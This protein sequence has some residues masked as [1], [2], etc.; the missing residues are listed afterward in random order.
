MQLALHINKGIHL[1]GE[2]FWSQNPFSSSNALLH[3]KAA[4]SYNYL[5][6]QVWSHI[7]AIKKKVYVLI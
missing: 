1:T 6:R 5:H 2:Q 7:L 4:A 3:E